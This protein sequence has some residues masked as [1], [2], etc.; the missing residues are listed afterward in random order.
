M[1][2]WGR[3]KKYKV[4]VR[5][6][7][8]HLHLNG[9]ARKLCFYTT[10]FVEAQDDH[11]AEEKAISTLRNDP[12]LRDRVL[13]DKSDAPMLFVEEIAELDSF[14]GVTLPG[15]GFSFYTGDEAEP[16]CR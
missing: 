2:R 11:E 4:F 3:M 6:Q 13:N 12:T 16:E 10:R 9:E 1:D 14:D 8:F 7:N 5:G 15:T